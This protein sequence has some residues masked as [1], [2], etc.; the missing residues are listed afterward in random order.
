MISN[1]YAY[2]IKKKSQVQSK[3]FLNTKVIQNDLNLHYSKYTL[4]GWHQC[5]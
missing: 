1:A 5:P 2:E 3:L 4:K